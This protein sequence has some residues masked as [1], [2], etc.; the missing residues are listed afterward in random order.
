MAARV[1]SIQYCFSE[2]SYLTDTLGSSGARLETVV[3]LAAVASNCVDAAPVLADARLGAALVQV[4][5]RKGLG[6]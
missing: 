4:Y 6:E 2:F 1:S 3:A 5:Q